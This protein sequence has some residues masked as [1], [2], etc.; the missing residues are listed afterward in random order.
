VEG[1]RKRKDQRE[2]RSVPEI[3]KVDL[4]GGFRA[5]GQGSTRGPF[6]TPWDQV[7]SLFSLCT[8]DH[9]NSTGIQTGVYAKIDTQKTNIAQETRTT[10]DENGGKWYHKGA[11]Y[12]ADFSLPLRVR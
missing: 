8:Y 4:T 12:K 3:R 5:I 2:N 6:F 11:R 1:G 10:K 9:P 7:G